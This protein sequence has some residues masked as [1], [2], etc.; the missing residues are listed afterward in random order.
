M[1]IGIVYKHT[2]FILGRDYMLKRVV[3]VGMEYNL[4]SKPLPWSTPD[5]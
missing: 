2:L 4:L 3:E 5:K 1:N